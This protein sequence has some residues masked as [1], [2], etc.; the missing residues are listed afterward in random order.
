M[1]PMKVMVVGQPQ[2]GKTSLIQTAVNQQ[3]P[4]EEYLQKLSHGVCDNETYNILSDNK[5]FLLG[6][7][8]TSGSRDFDRLRPLAYPLSDIFLICIEIS[9]IHS[10]ENGTVQKRW[11]EELNH[12]SPGV[13]MILIGTKSDLRLE[14]NANIDNTEQPLLISIKDLKN[15]SVATNCLMYIEI[16][17]KYMDK[18]QIKHMFDQIISVGYRARYQHH[19]YVGIKLPHTSKT[20]IHTGY[21]IASCHH[22]NDDSDEIDMKSNRLIVCGYV[23]QFNK[24]QK[25]NIPTEIIRLIRSFYTVPKVLYYGNNKSSSNA[26]T[27]QDYYIMFWMD[28]IALLM[29]NAA[30]FLFSVQLCMTTDYYSMQFYLSIFAFICCCVETVTIIIGYYFLFTPKIEYYTQL[31]SKMHIVI[32]AGVNLPMIM[33]QIIYLLSIKDKSQLINTNLNIFNRFSKDRPIQRAS[34]S[35]L[36]LFELK[37]ELRN[38]YKCNKINEDIS[39]K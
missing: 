35:T 16:S 32:E 37:K 9:D 8:D 19:R 34:A 25:L 20:K 7:W 38:K 12:H 39:S 13:P 30:Y 5:P 22:I 18:S 36:K 27:K 31:M 11:I 33:I 21:S 10:F 17:A 6:L 1:Q 2:S 23:Q 3:F 26:K 14:T 29:H 28:L 15:V 4:S 24:E